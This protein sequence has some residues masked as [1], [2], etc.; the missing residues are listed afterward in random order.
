[1]STLLSITV[2]AAVPRPL[3]RAC[4][5]ADVPQRISYRHTSV[6][7]HG[8]FNCAT[9]RSIHALAKFCL[10]ASYSAAYSRA[11]LLEP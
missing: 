7:V 2:T 9:D 1:M 4:R 3:P 8:A 11:E 5:I 10:D 6:S